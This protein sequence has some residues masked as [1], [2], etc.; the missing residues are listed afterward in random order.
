M[1]SGGP[2]LA[3]V[4]APRVARPLRATA[5]KTSVTGCAARAH[6]RS[7]QV[8]SL[9]SRTCLLAGRDCDGLRGPNIVSDRAG[10]AQL[11]LRAGIELAPNVQLTA[12]DFGPLT[13]A[14]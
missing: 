8:R 1:G 13:H 5:L 9:A 2:V 11:D 10:N 12:D 7:S 4:K 14:V 6:G 3:A